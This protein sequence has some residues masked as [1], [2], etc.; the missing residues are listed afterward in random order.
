MSDYV[1]PFIQN[2]KHEPQPCLQDKCMLYMRLNGEDPNTGER[3][4]SGYCA[5][6]I[7]PKLLM[8][9]NQGIAGLQKAME[10]T[11]NRTAETGAAII[12]SNQQTM[13]FAQGVG[14]MLQNIQAGGLIPKS[15]PSPVIEASEPS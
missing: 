6:A 11:R 15:V 12:K 3:I 2:K 14:L 13:D 10:E 4:N 5:M 9:N 8:E 1:C 7:T